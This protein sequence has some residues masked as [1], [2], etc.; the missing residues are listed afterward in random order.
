MSFICG[1]NTKYRKKNCDYDD[2]SK[3]RLHVYSIVFATDCGT[4][5]KVQL[6]LMVFK[7]IGDLQFKYLSQS[8]ELF[9]MH[10]DFRVSEMITVQFNMLPT[11]TLH[12]AIVAQYK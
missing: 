9:K 3:F 2:L 7:K 5:E 11:L 1:T 6:W 8:I 12:W 4:C 10:A